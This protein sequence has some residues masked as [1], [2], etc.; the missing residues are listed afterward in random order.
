[1]TGSAAPVRTGCVVVFY[2]PDRACVER[3]NRLAS[4]HRV[5][6]V[7]NSEERVTA[8]ALG[9]SASIAYLSNGENLGIATALNQGVGRLID[10]D[11]DSALLFDQDSS[12]SVELLQQLPLV[13]ADHVARGERIALVGPAYDDARLGGVAPFV[14]FRYFKLRRI[15]PVGNT[16]IDVDFL[17]TS[18]SC[19]N[20]RCWQE[21][22][23]MDD[24]LF[25]DFVDLEWCAR[26]RHKGFRVLGVPWL[27]LTHE[28]GD[29]PVQVLGRTYPMHSAVRH[30]YLFRNAV[31]LMARGYI[32]CTWKSTE[33]VK[34]PPRLLIYALLPPRNGV[35]L[36]MAFKG[37]W[38]A[39]RGRAGRL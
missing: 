5:V 28:L 32:P 35:H 3:A 2:R 6:V 9:L 1:M 12:P 20:L 30:Y 24:A 39:L 25:I 31:A 11:F 22:G 27:T 15:A 34:M 17:I 13:L 14:Q 4:V 29:E 19:V 21:I 23:P 18:G 38:H 7:D 10:E 16:P 26:A 36:K 8:E 37:I 33:L